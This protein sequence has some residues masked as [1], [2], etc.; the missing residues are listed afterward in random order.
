MQKRANH[1]RGGGESRGLSTV[2]SGFGLSGSLAWEGEGGGG[3]GG[4][5]SASTS[6]QVE[7]GGGVEKWG[8]EDAGDWAG[9]GER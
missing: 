1:D 9:G 5:V 8:R 3:S 4:R 7:E 6:W 2:P